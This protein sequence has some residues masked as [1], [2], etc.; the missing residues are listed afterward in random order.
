MEYNT[1]RPRLVMKE[2]GRT[3][4]KM[5]Q[6]LA[7]ISDKQK[8]TEQAIAIID[9]ITLFNPQLRHIEGYKQKL[10]DDLFLMSNCTLDVDAPF[11]PPANPADVAK[12][13]KQKI[14]YPHNTPKYSHLGRNIELLAKKVV[15]QPTEEKKRNYLNTL[16]YYI[17]TIYGNWQKESIADE[18]I[19]RE[20]RNLTGLKIVET[21]L[22]IAHLPKVVI[23]QGNNTDKFKKQNGGNPL[24]K[25][26]SKKKFKKK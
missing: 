21:D 10:W 19:L 5:V 25:H 7:T 2:Y 26:N 9:V 11:P 6:S 20:I 4:Q 14:A 17:K 1:A 8:R 16:A 18:V 13:I 23:I 15:D 3:I 12:K 24:S 22:D